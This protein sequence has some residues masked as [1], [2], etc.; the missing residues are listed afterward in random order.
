MGKFGLNVQY[1][2]TTKALYRGI[3][4]DN[5]NVEDYRNYRFNCWPGF[6]STSKEITVAVE[7]SRDG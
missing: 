2:D 5:F 4:K 1:K 7:R 6:T 3:L